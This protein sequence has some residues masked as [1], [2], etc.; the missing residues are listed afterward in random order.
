MRDGSRRSVSRTR[1]VVCRDG[2][3]NFGNPIVAINAVTGALAGAVGLLPGATFT[4]ARPGDAVALFATGFG[5]TSPSF[6]AGELPSAIAYTV[7]NPTVLLG[8]RLLQSREVIYAGVAP[9]LAGVYQLNLLIPADLP[10]GDYQVTIVLGAFS[11]PRGGFIT[12]RR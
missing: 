4:P 8:D 9:F 11:S 3:S 7:E 10:D 5:R 6:A 12:V 1:S 2:F